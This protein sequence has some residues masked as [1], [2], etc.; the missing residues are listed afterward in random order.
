[1]AS[2]QKLQWGVNGAALAAALTNDLRPLL[3]LVYVVF[4]APWTLQCW[5]G[6]TSAAFRNWGPMFWLSMSGAVMTLCEWFAFEILTFST[7]YVSTAHLA[8]QTLLTTTSVLV[9]HVPFSASVAVSTRIG[10][11]IGSGAVDLSRR[12][13][14]LYAIIFTSIGLLD[15]SLILAL[16][17]V[18]PHIFTH[19]GDVRLLAARAMPFV[20]IFQ[21]FDAT[22]CCAHGIIRGLGRQSIGAYTTFCINYIYVVPLALYLELGPPRL[23]LHGLWISLGSGLALTTIIEGLITKV[24]N[25][26]RC[27]DA[28][29][30]REEQ[31]P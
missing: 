4:V 23:G 26:Q 1:M 10:H 20:A 14:R 2:F 6:F 29:K 7:T 3:L 17:D 5:P 24:M 30:E 18:I 12:L 8:A 28:A 25:W 16:K 21:V 27:V 31:C 15:M 19:D 22:T 13:I 11:L 9:W